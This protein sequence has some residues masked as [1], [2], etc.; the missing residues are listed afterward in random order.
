MGE[1]KKA[2]LMWRVATP[3]DD[4]ATVSM[5][6]VLNAEGPGPRPVKLEQV[7]CSLSC[8]R[9]PTA[10]AASYVMLRVV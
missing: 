4:E 10:D 7:R 9:S 5:C 1:M 6:M 2:S 8:A 3:S